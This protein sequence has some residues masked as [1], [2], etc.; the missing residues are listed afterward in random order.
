MRTK[1]KVELST[2]NQHNV[3]SD[4]IACTF[5][6]NS[7][8]TRHLRLIGGLLSLAL[9]ASLVAQTHFCIGGDI[10]EMSAS[11][12][13]TCQTTMSAVRD[14]VKQHGAP[15]DWHFVVVCDDA[16]WKDYA[17]FSRSEAGLISGSSYSTDPRLHYTFLRAGER[18]LQQPQSAAAAVS[19]ALSSVPVQRSAPQLVTSAKPARQYVAMARH[20]DARPGAQ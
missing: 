14:A 15:A 13:A 7:T 5:L 4:G 12:I 9:S 17:S 11:D 10:D 20:S 1:N 19:L 3:P 16:G 18:N 8:L 2:P 6:R